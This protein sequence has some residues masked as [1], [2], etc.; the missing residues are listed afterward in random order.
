MQ[1]PQKKLNNSIDGIFHNLLRNVPLFD[2]LDK[3]ELV[4]VGKHI[5]LFEIDKGDVLFK[6]G[7]K[8]D[9][10]CILLNGS[11]AV[12]K[13]TDKNMVEIATLSNGNSVG[14]MSIV[15][16]S[17]RPATVKGQFKSSLA[18]LSRKNFEDILEKHPKIGVKV[19]KALLF[20]LS[21]NMRRTS[22]QLACYMED[23]MSLLLDYQGQAK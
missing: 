15:A 13:K 22:K 17:K 16:E 23:Y 12:Y 10:L 19:L 2:T 4:I 8:G 3:N 14:E 18:S 11:L 7:E 1:D 20:Y 21:I 9:S 6:E 5:N